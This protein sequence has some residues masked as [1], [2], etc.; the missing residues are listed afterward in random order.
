MM[1]RLAVCLIL[2]CLA[3]LPA[4][5]RAEDLLIRDSMYYTFDD[6]IMSPEE[7]EL[8]A[9]QIFQMCQINHF[10]RTYM[11]CKCLAG[12]FLIEREKRGPMALQLDIVNDITK[13][14]PVRC[15]NTDF[16]AGS[17]YTS[18]VRQ[19]RQIRAINGDTIEYCSCVANKVANDFTKRPYLTPAY[20]QTL[21]FNSMA[22]CRKP[23]N[24]PKTAS[25][26]A[27]K[28]AGET[29]ALTKTAN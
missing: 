5:A 12:A 14:K 28:N 13:K 26:E 22:F 6:G 7:M 17:T 1:H 4:S 20:V 29:Q 18:C 11:D 9:D 27:A 8:E 19:T 3:L 15:A 2:A 16:I 24:R 25:S 21:N 10:K 23:E